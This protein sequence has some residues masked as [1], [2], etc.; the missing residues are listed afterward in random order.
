[1]SKNMKY[2]GTIPFWEIIS[3]ILLIF[4][5]ILI[6]SVSSHFL[7][8]LPIFLKLLLAFMFVVCLVLIRLRIIEPFNKNKDSL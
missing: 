3:E 8:E 1:M 4:A 6:Y 5:G 2:L 7:E